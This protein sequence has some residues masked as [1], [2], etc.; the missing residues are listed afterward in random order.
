VIARAP[1]DR[2]S[3]LYADC[4]LTRL[5]HSSAKRHF[6]QDRRPEFYRSIKLLD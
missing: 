4:D 6:L 2:D 5:A 1:K 3:I